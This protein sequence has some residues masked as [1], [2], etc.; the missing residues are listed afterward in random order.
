[1]SALRSPH[2]SSGVPGLRARG[3]VE[4]FILW[5]FRTWVKGY[6]G[7]PWKRAEM[8]EGFAAIGA[9]EAGDPFDEALMMLAA[10]TTV[11]I[12]VNCPAC[13]SVTEDEHDVLLAIARLQRPEGVDGGAAADILRTWLPPAAVRLTIGRFRQTAE[14]LA[15]AGYIAPVRPRAPRDLAPGAWQQAT[16]PHTDLD[17]DRDGMPQDGAPTL[18]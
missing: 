4:Q 7:R 9:G 5:A 17:A 8:R 3:A 10:A 2:Q 6:E 11:E 14:A 16:W 1:M 18:H 12:G 15:E 13:P